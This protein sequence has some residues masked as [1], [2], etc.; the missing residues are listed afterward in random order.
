M[1]STCTFCHDSLGTNQAIEIFPVGKRLAFDAAKGRLWVVCTRCGG[2]NLSPLDERWE[3]IETAEQLFREAHLREN[4]D[5]IGLARLCD[6]TDLVRIGAPLRPEFAAWRY[7]ATFTHRR[8]NVIA[9]LATGSAIIGASAFL[10]PA[11]G[12]VAGTMAGALAVGSMAFQTRKNGGGKSAFSHRLIR[13]NEN[14]FIRVKPDSV[15]HVRL[16][17]DTTGWALKVPY[18]S[19]RP[20][21]ETQWRDYINTGTTAS[22]IIHGAEAIAA[23]RQLLPMIN[24]LGAKRTVIND[25]VAVASEWKNATAGFAYALAHVREWSAQQQFGDTGSLT[26]LPAPVRLALEMS[27]HE[28]EERLAQDGEFVALQQSWVEAEQVAAI[29]D[30]LLVPNSVTSALQRLRSRISN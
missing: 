9:S 24:G 8:R 7:G 1:Y 29:S 22:A 12:F 2:W 21:T 17:S 15:S 5:N 27:M 14:H 16:V 4:T 23:A 28:D 30:S 13:D 11:A 20:T 26:F 25:A 19:R 3:A 10:L 18:Q 6:G